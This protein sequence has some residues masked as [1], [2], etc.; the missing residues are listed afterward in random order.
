[1]IDFH[2]HFL[3]AM[4]DGAPNVSVALDMLINSKKQGVDTVIATPHFYP[5]G[6]S[7]DDFVEMREVAYS[8]L[9]SEIENTGADVPDI[10]LGAEVKVGYSLLEFDSLDKLCIGNTRYILLEMPYVKWEPSM[11]ELIYSVMIKYKVNP[12]IAHIERYTD[13]NKKISDYASLFNMDVLI[14][15]NAEGFLKFSSLRFLSKLISEGHVHVLGSDMHNMSNRKSRIGD[16][17]RK[18]NRKFGDVFSEFLE[19]NARKIINGDPIL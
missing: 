19:D 17:V 5:D 4:D 7:V 2:S 6:R 8:K 10:V 18:I 13:T 11:F 14:Q 16:A 12:I 15:A 3:P 9:L 1:M